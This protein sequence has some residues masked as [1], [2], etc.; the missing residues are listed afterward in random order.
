[1]TVNRSQINGCDLLCCP[2]SDVS[3]SIRN[4]VVV[5][6][7]P[8]G[9]DP[10]DPEGHGHSDHQPSAFAWGVVGMHRPLRFQLKGDIA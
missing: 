10:D 4:G 8:L 5:R 9:R 1:M 3:I 7:S 2:L 6:Q